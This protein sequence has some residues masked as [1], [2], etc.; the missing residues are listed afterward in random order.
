MSDSYKHSY[1]VG[2]DFLNSLS[3]YNVGYQKCEP[4][5][6]WGPGIRDHY[7]IHHILSGSGI[8]TTGKVSVRL[9]AGDTFILFPGV[10]L[11]YQADK[12]EPWEYCWAGFMGTDAA[13]IIRNTGFSKETPY[14][15]KGTI[16]EEEI[17]NGLD[18]IYQNKGNTY[19]SS[20]AMAGRL[21]SL[22]AVFMHYAQRTEPEKDSHVMYVEK[23]M[24]YIETN[25]SYPITVEDIAYYVGISRSHLFRS[26]QNYM[27]K[28]P[29]DYLSGYRIR[30]A[31]HLLR[32]TDLSVS[33]IAYSV[34]FE[35]NLYFSKAFRKQKGM[36]PSEYRRAKRK[37][38][39]RD[40]K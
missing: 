11:Q 20:V 30:Q 17:R 10:E 19:E 15:L 33:T 38:E 39:E 2:E 7:C 16:P 4:E 8:Y 28:S 21:Y 23:A 25:Y 34:G 35:N 18:E 6:Q 31:C 36:S 22:L 3:V 12:D 9:S 24:S 32:E 29:K 1:K 37:T 13:S 40:S 14:I 26:F 27:R 5:Y